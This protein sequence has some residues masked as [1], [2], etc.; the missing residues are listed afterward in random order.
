MF[1]FLTR[2]KKKRERERIGGVGKGG[3]GNAHKCD[4][5]YNKC[6][7]MAH[8]IYIEL[9][10]KKGRP[11]FLFKFYFSTVFSSHLEKWSN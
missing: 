5:L 3:R 1:F 6:K 10:T 7:I 11:K 8:H 4:S 2:R 9:L